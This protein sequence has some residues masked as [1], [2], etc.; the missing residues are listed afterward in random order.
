MPTLTI[1]NQPVQVPPDTTVLQAARQLGIDI[2]ALCFLEGCTPNTSCMACV[3]SVHNGANDQRLVPACATRVEEGMVVESESAT[4]RDAR[5]AALGLLLSDH[6]GE[7]RAPC[8]YA[9]PFKSDIPRM[10]R[11]I[12]A[13]QLPAA[14]ATLREAVP[15]PA[16]LARLTPETCEGAC[17][18]CQV[19]QSAA[20]GDLKRYVAEKNL[21][22]GSPTFPAVKPP[23][24][25]QVAIVGAGPA[26]LAAAYFL[27]IA[28]H[29]CR[30]YDTATHA[31]GSLRELA[32][33]HDAETTLDAEIGF[34]GQLGVAFELGTMLDKQQL[35]TLRQTFDAVLLATGTPGTAID[36]STHATESAGVFA[37]GGMLRPHGT[38]TQAAA[39]GKA[40]AACVDQYLRDE[41]ISG[42]R[43]LPI[44]ASARPTRDEVRQMA[45]S[46]TPASTPPPAARRDDALLTDDEARAEASRC[47][48]CD[49]HKLGACALQK[50]AEQY[51]VDSRVYRG[52]RRPYDRR[53]LHPDIV[54]EPGKCI[55]CGLCI[56]VAEQH[57]EPVG[58]TFVGRGFDTRLGV[59]FEESL[60]AA[61]QKCALRCAEV[62]PTGALAPRDDRPGDQGA[63]GAAPKQ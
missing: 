55:L 36:R 45:A 37:A 47:L 29:A 44:V 3:V 11:A 57:G 5:R 1:D 35:D 39:D 19:D 26:G 22:T 53:L 8:Q 52:A 13:G 33:R 17:R 51:Q 54:F 25:K 28:G 38:P 42:P 61:L 63:C 16:T 27:Q 15:L 18:R 30:V 46:V 34:I 50:Y 41:P 4:V 12:A 59:P 21:N 62:C 14:A 48:H 23:T 6:A 49:C 32:R 56:Q 2:P 60:A 40:A 9:C 20:I 10:L 58:L 31:G 7:C 43:K 24:G